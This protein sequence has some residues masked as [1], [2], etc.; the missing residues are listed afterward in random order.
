MARQKIVIIGGGFGGANTARVLTSLLGQEHKVTLIDRNIDSY[1]CGSFPLLIVGEREREQ[2]HRSLGSLAGQGVNFVQAEVEEID[3]SSKTVTASSG[4]LEYD[5]LV[6]ATGA[7]YDWGAVP[8]SGAAHSF[9]NLDTAERLRQEL[10]SFSKGRIAIAVAALPLQ[11][12][13]RAIRDRD[14]ARVGV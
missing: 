7:V 13:S 4:K 8:G 11:V 12:S 9:Y 1:L 5:Y 2:V 10:A 14:D 6:L 3:T